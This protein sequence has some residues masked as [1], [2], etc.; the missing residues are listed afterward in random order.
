MSFFGLFR[1]PTAVALA[2]AIGLFLLGLYYTFIL[3]AMAA[4]GIFGIRYMNGEWIW[5]TEVFVATWVFIFI[6]IDIFIW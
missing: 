6:M 1:I 4:G 5:R 3:I 2:I